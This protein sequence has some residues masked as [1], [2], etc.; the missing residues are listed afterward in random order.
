MMMQ[1]R[2][3][4]WQSFEAGALFRI[5]PSTI[6][7]CQD[8]LGAHQGC[9]CNAA[10]G[11]H[12]HPNPFA[13]YSSRVCRWQR[14]MTFTRQLPLHP[15]HIAVVSRVMYMNTEAGIRLGKAPRGAG[16]MGTINMDENRAI[17]TV[18]RHAKGLSHAS[19]VLVCQARCLSSSMWAAAK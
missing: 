10:A 5:V 6:V 3:S 12:P 19:R 17:S 1:Q 18:M 15:I 2:T 9:R 7:S 4:A 14:A 11:S 8:R 13:R 16:T